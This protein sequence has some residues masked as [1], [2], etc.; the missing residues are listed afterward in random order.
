MKRV[1]LE[2]SVIGYLT[3][4][5]SHDPIVAGHQQVTAQWWRTAPRNELFVSEVVIKEC[6]RGDAEAAA[7]RLAVLK[8]ITTLPVTGASDALAD[9]LLSQSATPRSQTLDAFHIAIATVSR[10]DFL[11]S[12]NFKHIVNVSQFALIDSICEKAGFIPP[13]LCT[14]EHLLG[15][16]P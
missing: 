15:D 12:W 6:S 10:M 8:G 9:E 11:V 3:S 4:R 7:E 13:I 16:S 5:P 1:Y 2:T 14:P